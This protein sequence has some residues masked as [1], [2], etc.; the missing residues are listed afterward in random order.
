MTELAK[1]MYV[2]D[3]RDLPDVEQRALVIFPGGNGDW[4]VQV[5]PKH[6]RTIEGVR[7]CTSGGAATQCPGL[8]PAIAEAYRAM[9]AA[10][11]GERRERLTPPEDLECELRAWRE[12]F[13]NLQFDGILNIVELYK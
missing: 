4:Y 12:K 9:L 7:I 1:A 11:N 6:G 5:A 2:T 8:G 3:D 10:Q 13:P